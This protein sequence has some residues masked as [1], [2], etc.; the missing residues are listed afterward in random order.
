MLLVDVSNTY[1]FQGPTR[2]VFRNVATFGNNGSCEDE[3]NDPTYYV[4]RWVFR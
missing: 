3:P 2:D 1:H 4:Q